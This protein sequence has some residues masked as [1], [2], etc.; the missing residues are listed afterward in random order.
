MMRVQMKNLAL[1][2]FLL[3][4]FYLLLTCVKSQPP[5]DVFSTCCDDDFEECLHQPID[6]R[7]RPKECERYESLTD[8]D[9]EVREHF[10]QYAVN[11]SKIL[12]GTP[13]PSNAFYA[14]VVNHTGPALAQAE[15]VCEATGNRTIGAVWHAELAAILGCNEILNDLFGPGQA[16]N[17]SRWQKLS[18]YTTAEPC[19]MCFS[20]SRFQRVGEVIYSTS[21]DFLVESGFGQIGV[22]PSKIQKASN[23]CRLGAGIPD[24]SLQTRV[25]EN[26]L[27]EVTEPLFAWIND[28]TAP[29]PAGCSRNMANV[30]TGS[31]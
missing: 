24:T 18:L 4:T 1:P 17:F 16:A 21:I 22:S 30:C 19:P 23:S 6:K 3:S 5:G 13:C 14:V 26:V 20:A 15:I 11:R 29:C 9:C 27:P 31:L 25:I 7:F 28:P 10:I 2:L 12:A 8:I